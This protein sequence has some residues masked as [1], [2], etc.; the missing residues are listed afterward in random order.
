MSLIWA[1]PFSQYNSNNNNT[2][3]LQ[4]GYSQATGTIR[5]S[6]QSGVSGRTGNGYYEIGAGSSVLQRALTTPLSVV[7]TGSGFN[8]R[9]ISSAINISRGYTFYTAANTKLCRVVPN[10][11]QGWS[12]TDASGNELGHTPNNLFNNLTWY[13]AEM[14]VTCNSGVNTNDGSVE[15]RFQGGNTMPGGQTLTV[16]GIN[17][18]GPISHV[19]LGDPTNNASTNAIDFADW[20]IWDTNG[21]RNNNFM[22]DR[23]L[24]INYQSGNSATQNWLFTGGATAW[25]SINNAPPLGTQYIS[26][27]TVGDISEFTGVATGIQT[28][29]IAAVV[30]FA[31]HLKTDAGTCSFR[32]GMNS[33]GTVLNAPS[34]APGTTGA[35]TYQ[36]FELDPNGNIQWTRAAVDAALRRV[37]RDS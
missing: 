3:V 14:K 9:S 24:W 7:G 1:E 27:S 8:Q 30:M 6:T 5:N 35:Y 13:W 16:N 18:N 2:I 26:S 20:I 33:A 34:V 22:G 11:S 32:L 17:L 28:N 12:I 23:R 21:T 15:F 31:Y 36:F 19:A 10:L 37:T 25:Q 29:D 4:S